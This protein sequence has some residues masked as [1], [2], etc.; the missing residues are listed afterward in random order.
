M[1][2]EEAVFVD[3]PVFILIVS[4]IVNNVSV[5]QA[6]DKL[7]VAMPTYKTKQIG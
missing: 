4:F 6:K 7:F 1:K 5:L 3:L 2:K